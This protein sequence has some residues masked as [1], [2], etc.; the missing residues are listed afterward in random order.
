MKYILMIASALFLLVGCSD[1]EE[2]VQENKKE[3]RNEAGTSL[4]TKVSP[5]STKEEPAQTNE[6]L[7]SI[8]KDP[9]DHL[10]PSS[11][12]LTHSS[13]PK[14][15]V[16][17]SYITDQSIIYIYDPISEQENDQIIGFSRSS[18]TCEVLYEA[19]E[20]IQSLTGIDQV[21]YWTEYDSTRTSD[22]TWSILELNVD[23]GNVQTIIKGA[24]TDENLPPML[25]TYTQSLNWIEYEAD[26]DGVTSNLI[27][28]DSQSRDFRT[29]VT[30]ELNENE[31]PNG[32]YILEQQMTG[33]GLLL[34]KA[35]SK[36]GERKLTL[37][38]VADSE[39]QTLLTDE[40]ILDFD[41]MEDWFA[42]TSD[43]GLTIVDSENEETYRYQAT[44]RTPV[45]ATTFV[46]PHTVAFRDRVENVYLAD[47]DTKTALSL[48]R[49]GFGHTA[50][51]P[52]YYN[53]TL[54]FA[55]TKGE[56]PDESV[57]FYTFK[58]K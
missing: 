42:Y 50:S 53:D 2:V 3:S 29:L 40:G 48:R 38:R 15:L 24:S 7:L 32:E 35:I 54:C 37:E 51:K 10:S 6:H 49:D 26:G 52:V 30:A 45:D 28:Y 57:T 22:V 34:H 41:G 58:M 47:L 56:S 18:E 11:Y 36:D 17:P 4:S 13:C 9:I 5:V 12:E 20:G 19:T 31:Q 1:K 43:E 46:N 8:S 39:K 55:V 44:A 25:T 27:S 14:G 21:L 23:T 16:A 33:N